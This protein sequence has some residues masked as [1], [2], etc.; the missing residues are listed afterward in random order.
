MGAIIKGYHA[1]SGLDDSLDTY[2]RSTHGYYPVPFQG[3]KEL[4]KQAFWTRPKVSCEGMPKG[5]SK[6]C[7]NHSA[8]VSPKAPISVWHSA[9]QITAH[10]LMMMM[11]ISYGVCADQG[12]DRANRQNT[13]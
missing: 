9:P 2:L 4:L 6:N 5:S 8:L 10:R 11:S 3:F 1:I 13:R 7:F 12:A